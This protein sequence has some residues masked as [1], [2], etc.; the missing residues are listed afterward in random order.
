MISRIKI[1]VSTA[2]FVLC[3]APLLA[4]PFAPLDARSMAMGDTGVASASAGRAA[5][6]NPALLTHNPSDSVH[7]VLPNL[8][9]SVFADPDALDAY[10]EIED[11]AYFDN[12]NGSVTDM[13]NAGN[14][15][16]FVN[17]KNQFTTLARDLDGNLG[18]L[19]EQPFRINATAFAAVSLP[20][21]ALGISVFAGANASIETSPIVSACDNQLLNDYIEFFEAVNSQAEL[22][23]AAQTNPTAGC[24]DTPIAVQNGFG[25]DITD[26]TDELTSQVLVAGVTVGELGVSFSRDFLLFGQDL[27]IGITP[28][29]Q[30]ITSYYAIPT[31]QQLDDENYDLADDLEDSK[32]EDNDLNLDIGI[33]THLTDSLSLGLTLKNL[34]ANRY[35][36]SVSPTTGRAATFDLDTQARLGIAWDA[37]AGLTLAADLDLTR[38]SPFFLG[39]DTQFLG[40]G[41]EWDIASTLRLRGGLRTNL[42]DSD[43]QALTAG[44]GFNIIAV[45]FDLGAQFGENNAGGALQ[46]GVTF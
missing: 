36:T 3:S 46:M 9:V 18:D 24:N 38:N 1:L 44:I 16:E 8:G 19:S 4:Q 6:F 34:I 43:D 30:T 37:A 2:P 5:L 26:P 42:A 32:Q 21:Q 17:A 10:Q 13:E 40:A 39:E 25:I 14:Q 41:V 33:A 12:I 20:R 35:T 7:I 27:S 45:Y 28:K 31:V 15:T 22:F 29:L 11:E 23:L